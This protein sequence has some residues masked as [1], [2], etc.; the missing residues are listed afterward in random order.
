LKATG[1]SAQAETAITTLAAWD[2]AE[3]PERAAVIRSVVE[4][5]VIQPGGQAKRSGPRF[6]PSRVQIIWRG[7]NLAA[8]SL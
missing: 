2:E 3:V 1:K 6:D 7:G 8:S 5:V 4:K